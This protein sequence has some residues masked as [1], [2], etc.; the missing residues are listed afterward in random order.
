MTEDGLN[1]NS[2]RSPRGSRQA[3][4]HKPIGLSETDMEIEM[5]ADSAIYRDNSDEDDGHFAESTKSAYRDEIDDD[6][7]S[8]SVEAV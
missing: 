6:I 7:V 2:P 5:A 4:Q 1:S 3:H 8:G